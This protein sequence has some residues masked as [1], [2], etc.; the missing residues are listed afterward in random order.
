M[1]RKCFILALVLSL[2]IMAATGWAQTAGRVTGTV[3]DQETGD[4]LMGAN[5]LVV[6]TSWGAATD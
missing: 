3:V 2:F 5:V 1:H 6:G 4:P